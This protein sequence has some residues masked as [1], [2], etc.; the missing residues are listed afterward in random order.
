MGETSFRNSLRKRLGRSS[1]PPFQKQCKPHPRQSGIEGRTLSR[2]CA[3]MTTLP[4]TGRATRRNAPDKRC[5]PR[6]PRTAQLQTTL[7]EKMLRKHHGPLFVH[8]CRCWH[9][10]RSRAP[11]PEQVQSAE[12]E[13]GAPS[14]RIRHTRNDRCGICPVCHSAICR[15]AGEKSAAE[16]S[17]EQRQQKQ[18][19]V[20]WSDPAAQIKCRARHHPQ[21]SPPNGEGQQKQSRFCRSNQTTEQ[22]PHEQDRR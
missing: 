1:S 5:S 19:Q 9:E 15:S 3:R 22:R 21:P 12:K 10:Y 11:S 8:Q 4:G 16:S 18:S 13:T 2:A 17:A 6:R 20:Q 7:S 14:A